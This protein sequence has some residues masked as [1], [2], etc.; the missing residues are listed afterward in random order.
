VNKAI[1]IIN[2]AIASGLPWP[3]IDAMV[4][5]AKALGDPVAAIIENLKLKTN[6]MSIALTYAPATCAYLL[7]VTHGCGHTQRSVRRRPRSCRS[8]RH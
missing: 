4:D 1:N 8:N 5:D 2:S 6:Q 3:D 7:Q